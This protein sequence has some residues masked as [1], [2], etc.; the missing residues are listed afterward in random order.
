MK[1]AI[2]IGTR[3]EIIKMSPIIKE[4]GRRGLNFFTIHTGQHYSYSMDKLFYEQLSL[5]APDYTLGIKSRSPMLQGE[6]TGRM[7]IRIEEVLLKE[8]PS[9]VLVE[10]DTNTVLAGSVCVS[11]L[12]TSPINLNIR[13]GHVE[14]GLRSYDRTMTEEINRVLSD[15]MSDYLFAP[16]KKAKE[17]AVKE[18]IDENRIYVTGNPVVDAV[19][20]NLKKQ[21][22]II[23]KLNLQRKKY[24]LVTAHRQENVDDECK[25]GGIIAGLEKIYKEFNIDMI[26]PIHPRTKKMIE[27]FNIPIPKCLRIIEPLGF[28]EMLQ[29]EANAKL[30]LTDS[31]G[32]QEESCIL[33]VPCVTLRENTERPETLEIGCNILAGTYP[34]RIL[35]AA[36]TMLGK[37][38]KWKN[39]FGNGHAAERIIDIITSN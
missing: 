7:L 3:P 9:I 37:K 27:K 31:G 38:I 17:S 6:H 1:I 19:F 21:T 18:G 4:C 26:Y 25:L 24:F 36:K 33:Q 22:N 35:T 29:L 5:P 12:K 32:L 11:K 16:T 14:A 2:I 28:L 10:G 15:H 30:I 13:L 8:K 34:K 39:P 23:E 20:Q